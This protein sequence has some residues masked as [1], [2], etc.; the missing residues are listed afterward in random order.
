[1]Q[2]LIINGSPRENGNCAQVINYLKQ[3]I[4]GEISVCSC[5]AE[6]IAHCTGCDAC[7]SGSC[8]IDDDMRQ[9]YEKIRRAD[10]I[11]F[12]SPLYF[13]MLTGGLLTF[14]SRWQFF[15]HN[16]IKTSKRGAVILLGGGST[17]DTS[18]AF[19]TAKIILRYAG[20]KDP[21]CAAFVGTDRE[22][23]LEDAEFTEKLN[24]LAKKCTTP[25]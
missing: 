8:A 9:Y 10:N 2:T 18:K 5:C 15:Y 6:N 16:P 21:D 11:I 23:P 7:K 17:K 25:S 14:A 12:V 19:S 13:S 3:N 1:M 22:A 20:I 24:K 4:G